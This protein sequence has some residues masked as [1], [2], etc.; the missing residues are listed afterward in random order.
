MDQSRIYLTPHFLGLF[1]CLSLRLLSERLLLIFSSIVFIVFICCIANRLGFGTVVFIIII[2]HHRRIR[3]N[4]IAGWFL[5]AA[6]HLRWRDKASRPEWVERVYLLF[7]ATLFFF[8][9]GCRG[10]RTLFVDREGREWRGPFP[11][12]WLGAAM[13]RSGC[14]V[15]HSGSAC[16]TGWHLCCK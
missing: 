6:L 11:A 14:C 3:S 10:W 7:N 5:V 2:I 9:D 15:S 12:L 8:G 4:G 16:G 1:F 13:V